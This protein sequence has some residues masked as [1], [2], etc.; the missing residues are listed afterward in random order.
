[1]ID[2]TNMVMYVLLFISLY[3]GV[4]L[5]ITYFEKRLEMK[6]ENIRTQIGPSHYPTVS[7]LI[8]VWNEETTLSK[9]VDSLLNL[10]YPKDKLKILIIDD[11]S[12]D[13]TWEVMKQFEN[14]PQ[15]ELYHKEN[16]G[17]HNALNFGLTKIT[18]DL[19]GCLDADS[20]VDPQAL[21][22]IVSYFEDSEVMAVT[23]SVRIY[24]P[25]KIIELM[26]K[27]EY[28]WGIF[29]RKMLSYMGALYVTPGPFSIFRKEVFE[30]LGGYRKAHMT[31]DLELAL[32]M[33]TNRYKIANAHEAFV[34]TVAPNTLH[35]LYKQRLRWTYGFLQ[36]IM[37]YRFL[38][39]K[40]KYGNL[41][42]FVLPFMSISLFSLLYLVTTSLVGIGKAITHEIV[43]IKTVGLYFTFHGF[44]F[45]WFSIN[46][47]FFAIL[48]SIAFCFTLLTIF[49]S[50]KMTEGNVRVGMDILYFVT[51]YS[52]IAPLWIA[53][54]VYN[55]IFSVKTS[56]R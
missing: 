18:T 52:F 16:G 14:N 2:P 15:I 21:R 25:K 48:S 49:I 45:N 20:Y 7:I 36:N 3:Y 24:N 27:V 38:F 23:P 8:P 31:E 30:N 1:M 19:V 22:T 12:T 9:T 11:G 37:D 44:D 46:T 41:G 26:Q 47:E 50:R 34:F 35:K 42:V 10:N 39:F 56:W 4:F 5:M 43:K 40:K 28:G 55:T 29:V 6:R 13:R 17:K 54:A 33:Q 51:F 32:R 53:K